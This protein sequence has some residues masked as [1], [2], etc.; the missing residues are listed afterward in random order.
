MTGKLHKAAIY[1]RVSTDEQEEGT[2]LEQQELDSRRYAIE[3]GIVVV[4]V[5]KESFT[6][7]LYRERKLLSTMREAYRRGEINCVIIRN[8]DRLSRDQTHFIV[9]LEEMKHHDV[10]LRCVKE[11]LDDTPM[12][13]FARMTMGLFA[14][15]ERNKIIDRTVTGK[16]NLALLKHRLIPGAK[17]LYG[18]QWNDP[19]PSMKSYYVLHSDE[20]PVIQYI[21]DLYDEGYSI[22]A[23]VRILEDKRIPS[24]SG[25]HWNPPTV[26]RILHNLAYTG[27]AYVFRYSQTQKDRLRGK[28]YT[29][30]PLDEQI[31]LPEGTVP[32][33]ISKEQFE[34]VQARFA[35]NIQDSA[36]NNK[37]PQM[38]LLRSGFAKCGYCGGNLA[39]SHV[40]RGRNAPYY[41]YYCPRGK[42]VVKACRGLTHPV[43]SLDDQV[44]AQVEALADDTLLISQA[45]DK[46]LAQDHFDRETKTLQNSLAQW[47]VMRDQYEQDL[48][49]P[50]L[51]GRARDRVLADLSDVEDTIA[52]IEA[53][54]DL[55]Q[56]GQIDYEAIKAEYKLIQAWCETVQEEREALT[57]DRKRNFLRLLGIEVIVYRQDDAEHQRYELQ[58][59]L[60]SVAPLVLTGGSI[61][62]QTSCGLF[63]SKKF[64]SSG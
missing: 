37:T 1:C 47:V 10:E 43:P 15:I 27:E 52:K 34:R 39:V 64:C 21:Y 46:A 49:N 62:A 9:L 3:N 54:I 17:P 44:W 55:V 26:R 20:S 50:L 40:G 35:A 4:A 63:C 16:R 25:K 22:R 29:I 12:G 24:P 18:Y 31:K 51:R 5:L 48:K 2:S 33:I 56:Q 59:K 41:S 53:E 7:T 42:E 57:Y 32:A 38:S 36:R 13:R 11:E 58:A 19:S 45:I 60:P 28:G 14:E 30:R 61:E 6:G 23:I 8:F